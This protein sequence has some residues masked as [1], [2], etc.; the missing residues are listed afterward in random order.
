M[1]AL[2]PATGISGDQWAVSP[3]RISKLLILSG[4]GELLTTPPTGSRLRRF[5]YPFPRGGAE[6]APASGTYPEISLRKTRD[7]SDETRRDLCNDIYPAPKRL[8]T[9]VFPY[10]SRTMRPA[11]L[12]QTFSRFCGIESW[13]TFELTHRV[14]SICSRVL[15]YARVAERQCRDVAADLIGLLVPAEAEPIAAVIAYSRDHQY[16]SQAGRGLD[17]RRAFRAARIF[18]MKGAGERIS[19]AGVSRVIIVWTNGQRRAATE[20][21]GG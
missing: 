14:R 5:E 18:Y 13:G 10:V 17:G 19:G 9:H 3:L 6:K 11:W 2:V 21:H 16:S 12:A 1:Q 4:F 8:E 20:Q 15:R 7:K